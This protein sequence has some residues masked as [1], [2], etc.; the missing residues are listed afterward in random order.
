MIYLVLFISVVA[1]CC[2][3]AS[4]VIAIRERKRKPSTITET[5]VRIERAPVE[6][7]FTY[8]EES[9]SYTLDGNLLVTGE[10]SA[11]EKGGKA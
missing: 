1:L 2:S 4:L 10:V 8:D 3:C 11:L 9:T 5:V 7:P 6:H